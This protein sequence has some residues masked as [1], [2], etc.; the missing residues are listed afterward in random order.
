M[1]RWWV[2]LWPRLL[3]LLLFV[4]LFF[5][6]TL[7]FGS[8]KGSVSDWVASYY[9][10][11]YSV[12]FVRRGLVGTLTPGFLDVKT[13]AFYSTLLASLGVALLFTFMTED[14]RLWLFFLLSPA[15]AL[16]LGFDAGRY[17]HFNLLLLATSLFLIRRSRLLWVIPLLSA[18][19]ILVH[20]GYVLYALPVI[21]S[22]LYRRHRGYTLLT[23]LLTALTVGAV[24]LFGRLDPSHVGRF[25]S[26][27]ATPDA[28][29]VLSLGLWDTVGNNLRYVLT[30]IL[31]RPWDFIVPILLL[32]CHFY[33][34]ARNLLRGGYPPDVVLAP[35]PGFLLFLFGYDYPRWASILIVVLFLHTAYLNPRLNP[36]PRER[37]LAL[38]L[39][40]TTLLGPLGAG[41][42]AFPIAEAL[43]RGTPPY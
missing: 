18:L 4:L 43:L 14:R 38:C 34:Y 17:D 23:A 32:G 13:F 3:F 27:G 35:V 36:S 25:V 39:M 1:R 41:H 20:E 5:T 24:V 16:H 6:P 22:A 11:D 9:Y 15:T 42:Y 30:E 8:P 21:L 40:A 26:R 28:V 2:P 7:P 37:R 31:R 19:G 10:V 33:L 12:G 29:E